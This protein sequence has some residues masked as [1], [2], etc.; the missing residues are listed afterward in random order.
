MFQIIS[1]ICIALAAEF[2]MKFAER[3]FA[4]LARRVGLA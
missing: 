3:V 4:F 1:Q 2:G